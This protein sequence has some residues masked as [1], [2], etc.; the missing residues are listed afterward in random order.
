M[1]VNTHTGTHKLTRTQTEQPRKKT[2]SPGRQVSGQQL[3]RVRSGY[4]SVCQIRC[5]TRSRSLTRPLSQYSVCSLLC[6]LKR[7][8]CSSA[9]R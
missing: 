7:D 4:G 5:V 9:V 2:A 8:V 1:T 6:S 3:G